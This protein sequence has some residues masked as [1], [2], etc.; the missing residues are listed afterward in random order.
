MKEDVK[1]RY[2]IDDLNEIVDAADLT[3][4]ERKDY[5]CIGCGHILRPV[6]GAIKKKHFR[7]K[8]L[9]E[10]SGETY[11]HK[12]AKLI[13]K[14]VYQNCV[15]NEIP[16][17]IELKRSIECNSC[18]ENGPCFKNHDYFLYDITKNFIIIKEEF[19]EGNFIP[20]LLL[21]T[22]SGRKIFVEI[23]VTHKSSNDKVESGNQIIEINVLDESDLEI[24]KNRIISYKNNKILF[25]NFKDNKI[26]KSLHE[27]CNRYMSCFALLKSGKA[28]IKNIDRYSY[29]KLKYSHSIQRILK[30]KDLDHYIFIEELEKSHF[31]GF[32]VKNCYLCRYHGTSNRISSSSYEEEN[33][34]PIFCKFLKKQCSSNEAFNCKS[35]KI[36]K[37]S[38]EINKE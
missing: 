4:T 1:Y 32:D 13:F 23:A 11:L 21:L 25:Y 3:L 31:E 34:G 9:V 35:Y 8:E 27:A 30:I 2:A 36:D 14:S 29:E 28:F 19:R 12:L 6:I 10:C 7:H 33:K 15:D 17:E 20:D 18:K 26:Q 22:S 5:I 24:I 38:F 16:F 37:K